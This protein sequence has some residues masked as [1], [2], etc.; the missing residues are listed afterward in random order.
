MDEWASIDPSSERKGVRVA[1]SRNRNLSE[2]WLCW[3]EVSIA[4]S[5]RQ[6]RLE[7]ALRV[8][9]DFDVRREELIRVFGDYLGRRMAHLDISW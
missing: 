3:T 9:L 5:E 2:L 6:P 4:T 8:E 1:L 7:E